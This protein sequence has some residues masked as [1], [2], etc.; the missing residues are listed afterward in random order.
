MHRQVVTALTGSAGLRSVTSA[1]RTV[2]TMKATDAPNTQCGRFWSM[3]QPNNSGLRMPLKL[4]PVETMPKARPAAPAGAALRT[5]MSREG[6][7]TPPRNPA[8]PI[9]AVSTADGRL[10]VAMTMMMTA[11]I[12]KHAAATLP[13]RWVR[14]AR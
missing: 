6:A 3:I 14:S 9:A 13:W 4:K 10:I 5:S 12:A 7:I 1:S 11:L 2:S 8:S